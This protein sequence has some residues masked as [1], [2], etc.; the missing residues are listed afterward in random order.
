MAVVTTPGRPSAPAKKKS[1][2]K[3]AGA[4]KVGRTK[5]GHFQLRAEE[6]DI[7]KWRGIAGKG[8]SL[9][10]WI[11]AQLNRAANYKQVKSERQSLLLVKAEMNG[12]ADYI[13]Q[14]FGEMPPQHAVHISVR[15][16]GIRD[17]LDVLLT[18]MSLRLK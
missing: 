10:G 4:K 14:H 11:R 13:R 18:H 17:R 16:N 3:R 1:K 6:D 12:L 9:S 2:T 15:L 5:S 8:K 7:E